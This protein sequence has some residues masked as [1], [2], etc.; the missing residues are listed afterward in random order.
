VSFF[1][2]M[3]LIGSAAFLCFGVA[4]LSRNPRNPINRLFALVML[5]TA[6]YSF[7]EFMYRQAETL[8]R[9]TYWTWNSA[10]WPIMFAVFLHFVMR[11]TSD[12]RGVSAWKLLLCYVPSVVLALLNIFSYE[13]AGTR[14]GSWTQ[15]RARNREPTRRRYRSPR[16]CRQGNDCEHSI[17]RARNTNLNR[18]GAGISGSKPPVGAFREQ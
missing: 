18:A 1:A 13:G 2:F 16:R 14:H 7:C 6:G 11:V 15:H 17:S 10:Y 8:E 5:L 3:S 12:A 9:A 4:V